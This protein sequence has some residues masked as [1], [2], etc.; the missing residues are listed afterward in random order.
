M[1]Y[2]FISYE[3]IR[4]QLSLDIVTANNGDVERF[5]P[6]LESI[7]NQTVYPENL[8]ILL[9]PKEITLEK[10]NDRYKKVV[11]ILSKECWIHVYFY[12]HGNSSYIPGKGI[13]YDRNRRLQK[14]KSEFVYLIDDDNSFDKDFIKKTVDEYIYI[15]S[16][17][18]KSSE[19]LIYSPTVLY[20]ETKEIQ[21]MW[22]KSLF[23]WFPKY[24]MYSEKDFSSEHISNKILYHKV[25]LMWGNSLFAKREVLQKKWFDEKYISSYEDVDMTLGF[26]KSWIKVVCSRSN[27]IY[28]HESKLWLLESKFLGSNYN[29]YWRSRSRLRFAYKY[30]EKKTRI[31][32][33]CVWL[34]LQTFYFCMLAFLYTKWWRYWR[35]LSILS[36]TIDWLKYEIFDLKKISKQYS[37][38]E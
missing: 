3:I 37:K 34:P 30:T 12:R 2:L 17:E 21:S 22:I 11:K 7:K 33:L 31:L 5:R 24:N 16:L 4:S 32:Y 28:H 9:Y 19:W 23:W 18:K 6:F 38:S 29:A 1:Y 15:S 8:H 10:S 36:W 13:W 14:A 25:L 26:N 20:S 35:I 27:C